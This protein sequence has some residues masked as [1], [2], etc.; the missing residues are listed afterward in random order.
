MEIYIFQDQ[1]VFSG[2]VKELQYY[3]KQYNDEYIFL[4][5]LIKAYLP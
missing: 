2:K 5:D 3:L 4:Q 1:V